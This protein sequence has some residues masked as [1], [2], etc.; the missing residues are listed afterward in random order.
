[1]SIVKAKVIEFA[2]ISNIIYIYIWTNNNNNNNNSNNY[3]NNKR[4]IIILG[5][6]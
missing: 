5:I 1:M 4:I 3:N 6:N 2:Y